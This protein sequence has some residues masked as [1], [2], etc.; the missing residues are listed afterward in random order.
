[1]RRPAVPGA[2]VFD[3][4]GTM[5]DTEWTSYVATKEVFEAHGLGFS[6][7]YWCSL[8]GRTDH[9]HWTQML[10]EQ[11]GEPI[12]REHWISEK[13][14]RSWELANELDLMPGVLELLEA[15]R[16]VRVP[17]AVA[18]A[19][20]RGWVTGHLKARGLLHY[21]SA[22]RELEDTARTKPHPDPYLSACELLGVAPTAAVA[23]E[24]SEAGVCAAHSAGMTVVAI[25]GQL[26]GDHDYGSAD[27]IVGSCADLTVATLAH[28]QSRRSGPTASAS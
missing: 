3:F 21:F 25:P 19:S 23:L 14:A 4:D 13:T 24:D 1:M 7:D 10:E 12:D 9:P 15:L 2:V 16:A 18:S 5:L 26:T 8:V 17:M 28:L 6:L 11:L 20:R 27:V 22:V